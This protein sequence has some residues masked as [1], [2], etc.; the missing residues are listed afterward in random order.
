[1]KWKRLTIGDHCTVTS[2]KRFHI[3]DRSS[4]GVPFYCSKEIIQM[5][6]GEQVDET[7]YI[8]EDAYEQIKKRYGIPKEGDL[9]ITT[10]G[11][12][13]IPYLY[14]RNDRFY[15]ADGN[16]TWLKDFDDELS[17]E[18]LYYWL[19][20]YTG[21]KKIEAIAKGTAQKAVPIS[22]IQDLIIEAPNVHHQLEIIDKILPYDRLIK[23]NRLQIKLL[24]EAAQR[25][26]KEWFI[27]HHFPGYE[28]VKIVDSIPEGWNIRKLADV[29]D[30][31]MGQSPTSDTFN[32]NRNGLPF[33]QGVGSYGNRY[34]K[35]KVYTT[36]YTR[37]ANADSILFSVRAPVG[38]LNVTKN[39]IVIGRGL[40]AFNQKQGYQNYLF[41]MLK[42]HYFKDD[43]IGN[44]SIFSSIT[45][46]ELMNQ[47]FIIPDTKTMLAYDNIAKII[48]K[49]IDNLDCQIDLISEA[50]NRLLPKLM[51]G[52]IEI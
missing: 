23:S 31:I 17:A 7:D 46:N 51:S 26:Y 41:Y 10:R 37:I 47:K 34:V 42:E 43:L 22:A 28:N 3:S 25:L 50:R 40:A 18:Y 48:D 27:D 35:N 15:F 16:L 2:S 11:T 30:I 5:F 32:L 12:L 4:H 1:M 49:K 13:G 36:S 29:A 19:Q 20:S 6:N 8:S 14:K 44:G 24:E 38:R 9:L 21:K 33:H 45:K 39:K 52:E